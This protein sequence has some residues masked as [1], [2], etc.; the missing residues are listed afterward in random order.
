MTKTKAKKVTVDSMTITVTAI[1]HHRNGCGGESFEVVL[2]DWQKSKEEPTHHMVAT[3]RP[4]VI[5]RGENAGEYLD[6]FSPDIAVLDLDMCKQGNIA[7]AMGNSWRGDHFEPCI[8]K[9]IKA[10]DPKSWWRKK[11]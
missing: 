7:M 3:Y 11:Q 9:V 6:T 8:R 2:F 5:L 4:K 1:A 10:Q